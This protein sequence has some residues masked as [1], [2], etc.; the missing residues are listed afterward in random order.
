MDVFERVEKVANDLA[1]DWNADFLYINSDI[2]DEAFECVFYETEPRRG[3]G[4]YL[5]IL[6]TTEGGS[7][8]SAHKIMSYFKYKYFGVCVV[9][10]G[11][12]KHA[13]KIMCEEALETWVGRASGLGPLDLRDLCD[14]TCGDEEA[15]M[16]NLETFHRLPKGTDFFALHKAINAPEICEF[17]TFREGGVSVFSRAI[18]PQ[19]KENKGLTTIADM[20]PKKSKKYGPGSERNIFY[21]NGY[22]C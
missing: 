2:D 18:D 22:Y 7:A 15:P 9:A 11:Q 8:A 10:L 1:D 6:L 17:V 4:E 21:L 19:A 20:L 5:F 14:S 16:G 12:C 13:G 3:K